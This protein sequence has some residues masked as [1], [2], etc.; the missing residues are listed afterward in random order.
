MTTRLHQ[1]TLVI[2]SLALATVTIAKDIAITDNNT[3][4]KNTDVQKLAATAV[5]MGVK[6]P[7]NLHL[8]DGSLR[9]SGS[10][11]TTCTIKVGNGDTPQIAGISCQ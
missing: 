8:S 4:Y 1:T 7:V 9:V 6:E 2:L 10:S 11:T 3:P 5:K